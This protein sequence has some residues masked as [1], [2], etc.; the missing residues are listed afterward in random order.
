MIAWSVVPGVFAMLVLVRV[1]SHRSAIVSSPQR[2]PAPSTLLAD[3][4]IRRSAEF[5]VPIGAMTLLLVSRIPETLLLLRLQDLGVAVSAMPLVWAGLHVVRTIAAY[6]GGLLSDRIGP[7]SML[8]VGA[9]L[10]G[11]VLLGLARPLSAAK[12]VH[13][14]LILGLVTGLVRGFGSEG[15]GHAVG[16]GG[17]TG[18]RE[19]AGAGRRRRAA[20][21][22]RLRCPVPAR[23][24]ADGAQGERRGDGALAGASGSLRHAG[25]R[26]RRL[27]SQNRGLKA[28][29]VSLNLRT[30]RTMRRWLSGYGR[31]SCP[32]TVGRFTALGGFF[33]SSSITHA[34]ARS[35]CGS[36]PAM[37][38][39]GRLL[40]RDVRRDALVLHDEAFFGVQIARFGDGDGSAIHQR[41]KAEDADQATPGALPDQRADVN[42]RNIQGNSRRPIRPSRRSASPWALDRRGRGLEVVAVARRP[43][44]H[45]AD[46]AGYRS[47]SRRARRR[48]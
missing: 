27:R 22:T 39:F 45:D 15:R 43:V 26:E 47:S 38:S 36:C 9:V 8:A 37:T 17:R 5:W 16:W 2:Q 41:R 7:R 31:V 25:A 23:R 48:R 1:L 6:P 13:V 18:V 44:A 28:S 20:G 40:H 11:V 3:P 10:F 33:L 4:P 29:E 30:S 12:A 35:S 32:D 19:R 14:F 21:G 24:R 46:A 42:F 34:I